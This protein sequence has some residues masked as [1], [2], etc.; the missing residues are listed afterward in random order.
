MFMFLGSIHPFRN[1]LR[2]QTLFLCVAILAMLTVH[3]QA[4][5]A[6]NPRI[7]TDAKGRTLEAALVEFE[8]QRVTLRLSSD[9]R[10]ITFD[11]ALLSEGDQ[12]YLRAWRDRQNRPVTPP[13]RPNDWPRRVGPPEGYSID[14][15]REDGIEDVYIYRSR[16]F[17]FHASFRLSRDAVREF[18]EIFEATFEAIDAMPLELRP[19]APDG[20]FETI[21]FA[22]YPSYASTTGLPGSAGAYSIRDQAI[23]V[24]AQSLGLSPTSTG[25]RLDRSGDNTTL[26]H[27][28]THQVTHDWLLRMP[29]WLAE[30]LAVYIESVPYENGVFRFSQLELDE[31]IEARSQN[32]DNLDLVP[33]QELMALSHAD[34]QSG[35]TQGDLAVV[36]SR[37]TSAFVLTYYFFHLDDDGSGERIYNY[38][39]ALESGEPDAV[40]SQLLLDGRTWDELHEDVH[41]ALRRESIR[42][43]NDL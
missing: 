17:Q 23:F 12:R 14:I 31:A 16:H 30:G 28:I 15:V 22:D 9:G 42:L 8:G 3:L 43:R 29:I 34:W 26:I 1:P 25:F 21:L 11:M 2:R 13:R 24:P 27:E 6:T 37:Y 4:Q 32:P 5:P 40:A 33:P 36:A 38:L 19:Q 7:W 39:R 35:F 20:Y 10:L 18:S 41:R